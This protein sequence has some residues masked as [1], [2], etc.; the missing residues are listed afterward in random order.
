MSDIAFRSAVE[1]AAAIHTREISS[2]ELL[3]HCLKRVE[4]SL[5]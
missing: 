3:E 2:R 5:G 4:R 1:L